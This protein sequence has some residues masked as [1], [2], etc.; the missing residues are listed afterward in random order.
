[1]ADER[2]NHDEAA[3][4][5]ESRQDKHQD[6][7]AKQRQGQQDQKVRDAHTRKPLRKDGSDDPA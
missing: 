4:V 5:Q 2:K 1:M 7:V 6:E 3:G